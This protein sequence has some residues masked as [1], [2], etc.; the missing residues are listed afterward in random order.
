MTDCPLTASNRSGLLAR[1][2]GASFSRQLQSELQRD[3]ARED[4][5]SMILSPW[6]LPPPTLSFTAFMGSII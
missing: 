3:C 2:L 6:G 5:Q 4:L 1:P